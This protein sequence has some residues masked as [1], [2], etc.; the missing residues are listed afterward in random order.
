[1]KEAF[2]EPF[3]LDL[4]QDHWLK[5]GEYEGEKAG[6]TVWHR[7]PDGSMC[8]GWISFEGRAWA[9]S[10]K[11]KIATWRVVVED[12]C[13]DPELEHLGFWE[14]MALVKKVPREQICDRLGERYKMVEIS[15]ERKPRL[16]E[17]KRRS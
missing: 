10:F 2:E 16:L 5:Y 4:G 11:T 17:L 14:N 8:A 3:D 15:R 7:K 1:M 13:A 9:R 12:L 6:A